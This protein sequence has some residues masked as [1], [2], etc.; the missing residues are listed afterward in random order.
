MS[1]VPSVQLNQAEKLRSRIE[2]SYCSVDIHQVKFWVVV[3]K[4]LEAA[5][6]EA[7]A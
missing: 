2:G 5:D 6:P 3:K 1:T 7:R 4:S